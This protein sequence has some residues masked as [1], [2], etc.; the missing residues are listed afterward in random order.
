MTDAQIPLGELAAIPDRITLMARAEPEIL[1]LV[2]AAL[3]QLWAEHPEVDDMLRV[4]FETAVIEVLGNII[5]H[6]Y[7]VDAE[8]PADVARSRRFQLV[9]GADERKVMAAFGDNG[10]PAALD[11]SDVHMPGEDAESGRGL[12]LAKAALDAL[13]Y[14]RVD[15]RNLWRLECHRMAG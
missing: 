8:L 1:E 10:E 14:E 9:L 15:G 11:L 7:R 5:E 12:P 3:G 6:A 4:R 13:H 2:H